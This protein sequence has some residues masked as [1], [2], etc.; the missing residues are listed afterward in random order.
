MLTSP[1]GGGEDCR[2]GRGGEEGGLVENDDTTTLK[3]EGDGHVARTNRPQPTDGKHAVTF[4]Y[5]AVL[6]STKDGAL[7]SSGVCAVSSQHA[8]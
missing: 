7:V 2:G 4:V 6:C 5:T 1:G 3:V 8:L